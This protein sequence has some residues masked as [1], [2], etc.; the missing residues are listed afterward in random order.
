MIHLVQIGD[1]VTAEAAR[2]LFESLS[3]MAS[4]NSTWHR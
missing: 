2:G 1:G 3:Q 4:V